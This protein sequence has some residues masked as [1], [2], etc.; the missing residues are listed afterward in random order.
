MSASL[1]DLPIHSSTS[2]SP[3]DEELTDW[4]IGWLAHG[5]SPNDCKIQFPK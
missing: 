1:P 4:V 3:N 5:L 2:N